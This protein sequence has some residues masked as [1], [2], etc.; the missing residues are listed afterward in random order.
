MGNNRKESVK[1]KEDSVNNKR[2]CRLYVLFLGAMALVCLRLYVIST[3][4]SEA[5]E[6]LSGQYTR[7]MDVVSR[8]GMIYDRNGVLLSDE[9]AGYVAVLNPGDIAEEDYGKASATLSR[10]GEYSQSYFAEKLYAGVPFT[11]RVSQKIPAEYGSSYALYR[12]RQDP[13]LCHL[14]GYRNVDG[15]GMAGLEG[16]YDEYLSGAA[17]AAVAARYEAD[18]WGAVMEG[19]VFDIS[20]D[21]YADR[22]G[23]LLTIDAEI[24]RKVETVCDETMDMGA[25]VVQ[26]IETGELLAMCSRPTFQPEQVA[27]YLSSEKGELLNRCLMAYTPGSVFKT[28]VAAAALEKEPNVWETTY[29]CKGY[30]DVYG[31]KIG[32]HDRAG[33]GILDMKGGFAQSCNPYFI[34]LGLSL[35]KQDIL[36][37]AY[38]M[39]AGRYN[40]IHLLPCAE[41]H[42]PDGEKEIPAETANLSVGQGEVLLTPVQVCG[43]LSTAATGVYHKPSLVKCLEN[44]GTTAEYGASEG[45]PVLSQHTVERL[46]EMFEACVTEGTGYRAISEQVSCGGKTATA[47][48]G[49]RKEGEEVIHQWFAG[50]FPAEAP[51]Y[52]VCV[53][54]DGN[55]ENNRH[56]SEIF[57]EIAEKLCE[58]PLHR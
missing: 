14:L 30:I 5:S 58:K 51:Q 36:Q 45:E 24:Q 29:D 32:C 38:K 35:G 48:S 54:C 37:M 18:A 2:L 25:V 13:F 12:P 3:D 26:D 56:P 28:V 50:F 57:R 22:E 6:V 27:E 11:V 39:G 10:L 41:G 46:R 55:G 9:P 40:S 7:R 4:G 31:E 43:I 17:S 23:M 21:G 16:E 52:A 47:Q 42:L 8:R 1:R 34:S 33:H 49:Q 15:K 20:D 19:E 53:L 44:G